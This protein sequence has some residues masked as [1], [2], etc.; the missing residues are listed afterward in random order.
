MI[1]IVHGTNH[2]KASMLSIYKYE[3]ELGLV[4]NLHARAKTHEKQT[5][6]GGSLNPGRPPSPLRST[7]EYH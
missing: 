1:A 5:H 7:S 4:G 6:Q 3:S 2:R